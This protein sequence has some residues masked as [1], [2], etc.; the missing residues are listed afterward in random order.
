MSDTGPRL[1]TVPD[2][3]GSERAAPE[4]TRAGL[5]PFGRYGLLA[6]GLALVAVIGWGVMAERASRLGASLA[7]SE[8]SLAASQA[9][10][11]ALQG[12]LAQVQERTGTLVEGM[13]ALMGQMGALA[14][15]LEAL[16]TLVEAGPQ[17]PES[18][19]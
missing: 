2:G 5:A 15:D 17:A 9:R 12:H 13:G 19:E 10:V 1:I 6:A 3:E 7:V 11:E 18:P 8:A 14:A 4:E 16:G